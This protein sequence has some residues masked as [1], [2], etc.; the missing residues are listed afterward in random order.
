MEN[1]GGE[2][3]EKKSNV[4]VR[5]RAS[6]FSAEGRE[7]KWLFVNVFQVLQNCIS[8]GVCMGKYF[9]G[10]C[11]LSVLKLFLFHVYTFILFNI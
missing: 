10:T 8:C 4:G 6:E 5:R 1:K 9:F 2:E 3:R 11:K 7:R